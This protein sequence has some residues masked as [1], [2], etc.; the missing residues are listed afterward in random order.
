MKPI[1]KPALRRLWRDRSTLQF[2]LDPRYA[3]LLAGV[4]PE[5]VTV[6]GALDGTRDTAEVVTAAHVAGIAEETTRGILDELRR[7]RLIDDA[8]QGAMGGWRGD[9]RERLQPDLAALSL[10]HR[11]PAAGVS[12]LAARRA[13][14]VSV[15]GA[16]RVGAS[17]AT[18][19]AAEGVGHL[20]ITDPAPVRYRDLAP[21]GLAN[22]GIG[23]SREREAATAVHRVAGTV[24]TDR[25]PGRKPDLAVLAPVGPLDPEVPAALVREGVPHLFASVREITGIVGP[26]VLAG[27]SA[28]LRCQELHRAERDP[29]WPRIATQLESFRDNN[30]PCE[31]TLA[32]T[33][34]AQAATQALS[35]LDG[36]REPATLDGTLEVDLSDWRWRRRSWD[37]HPRCSCGGNA[38]HS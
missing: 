16:G 6:L 22:S 9:D 21:A 28:C 14:L 17:I 32:T 19:L 26:L 8:E 7:H 29:Y 30:D 4:G 38:V 10:L 33:V 13:M 1:I 20:S 27:R 23:R 5:V 25:A 37:P 35:Y 3:V 34:S 24:R 12:V 2:G 15:Y 36:T 31:S 18:L 11:E